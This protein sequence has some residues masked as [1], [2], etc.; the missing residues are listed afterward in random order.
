MRA[1][2]FSFACALFAFVPACGAAD[3]TAADDSELVAGASSA[4]SSTYYTLRPDLRRCASPMCGGVFVQRVNR[5][6]T[7]CVDGSWASECYVADVSLDSLGF[8]DAEKA[9]FE[10]SPIVVRGEI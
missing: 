8:T 1:L 3:A 10:S 2:N 9:S 5:A 7:R 4:S 6:S